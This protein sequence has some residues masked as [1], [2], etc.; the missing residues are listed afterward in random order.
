MREA[1][2]KPSRK[3]YDQLLHYK[4][5]IPMDNDAFRAH[6][7]RV[8]PGGLKNAQNP[9]YGPGWYTAMLPKYTAEYGEAAQAALQG[10]IDL[11]FPK[12]AR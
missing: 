7:K 6:S 10:M 3:I 12:G 1:G 9:L 8:Y 2:L 11:Y 5:V 4:T